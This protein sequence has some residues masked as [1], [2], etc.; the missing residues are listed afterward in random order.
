MMKEAKEKED[1]KQEVFVALCLSWSFKE[2]SSE[3]VKFARWKGCVCSSFPSG[4]THALDKTRNVF[5]FLSTVFVYPFLLPFSDCESVYC[6][7]QVFV[8]GSCN[9]MFSTKQNETGA[10][11]HHLLK[12][13]F[14]RFFFGTRTRQWELYQLLYYVSLLS[15]AL[16]CWLFLLLI[17]FITLVQHKFFICWASTYLT[18]ITS[19]PDTC[20]LLPCVHNNASPFLLIHLPKFLCVHTWYLQ[21]AFFSLVMRTR[22]K[23]R[24]LSLWKKLLNKILPT[25]QCH[26]LYYYF[27]AKTLTSMKEHIFVMGRREKRREMKRPLGKKYKMVHFGN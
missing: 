6:N 21:H 26:V 22:R 14:S 5:S 18:T 15:V 1:E 11:E 27:E 10:W 13:M 2:M 7:V 20:V 3:W 19:P 23:K 9:F 12:L 25:H 16:V 17:Y 24:A 8:G 4:L